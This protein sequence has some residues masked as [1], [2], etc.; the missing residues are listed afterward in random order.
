MR[1]LILLFIFITTSIYSQ[2]PNLDSLRGIPNPKHNDLVYVKGHTRVRDGGEGFF[3]YNDSLNLG[4]DDGGVIIKPK[5]NKHKTKGRW[6]RHLDG[7]I[8]INYLGVNSISAN[9]NS[10]NRWSISDTIQKAIDFAA[11]N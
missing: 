4:E 5:R 10:K 3:F 11:R 7:N 8:N 6:V 9:L 1:S 2:V